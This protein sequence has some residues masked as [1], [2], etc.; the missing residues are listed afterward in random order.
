MVNQ[1]LVFAKPQMDNKST[2]KISDVINKVLVVLRHEAKMKNVNI[3]LDVSNNLPVITVDEGSLNEV[4]FNIIHNA[5]QAMP[6]AGKLTISTSYD[7]KNDY[8]TVI[9]DNTGP[10][11]SQENMSK[12]FEPFY[13]TKQMG[14]GLGLAIVKKK[15]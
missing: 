10:G 5:I 11:I 13:T 2:V 7:K 8:I 1:L 9:F 15:L 4:F 12:I 14:T 3:H 6:E